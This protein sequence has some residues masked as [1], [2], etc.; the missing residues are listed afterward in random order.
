MMKSDVVQS[1]KSTRLNL[2]FSISPLARWA[3]TIA[4]LGAGI[5]VIVYSYTQE[6]SLN[7]QLQDQVARAATTLEQNN[8]R[9]I[10]L[11]GQLAE[12]NLSVAELQRQAAFPSSRETMDLEERLYLAGAAAGVAVN[13]ISVSGSS[14]AEGGGYQSF[15]V[16]VDVTGPVVAQLGF[17][18]QLGANL[19]TAQVAICKMYG[20]SMNMVLTVYV[21]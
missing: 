14:S 17:I 21:E 16:T 12:A 2:S 5:A 1:L 19:P 7:N 15:G 20:D 8:L 10:D 11:N 3:L 4:I 13:S 18:A 9:M 6:H